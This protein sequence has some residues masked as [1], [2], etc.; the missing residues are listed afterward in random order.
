MRIAAMSKSL[1]TNAARA[2]ILA[3]GLFVTTSLL[4]GDRQYGQGASDTEI[5]IGQTM[6]YGGPLQASSVI[7]KVQAAYFRMANAHHRLNRPK[8]TLLSPRHPAPPP[9][10][11]HPV[12]KPHHH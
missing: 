7:C 6:P 1:R 4:A 11:V 8:I 3:A 12:P 10:P 2:A 5:K 9:N